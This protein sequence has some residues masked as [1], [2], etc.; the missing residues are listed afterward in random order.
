MTSSP[1]SSSTSSS[2][3]LCHLTAACDPVL[4]TSLPL[5]TTSGEEDTPPSRYVTQ[6]SYDDVISRGAG[7][8]R[9]EPVATSV[10]R[11]RVLRTDITR[12]QSAPVGFITCDTTCPLDT[13][14]LIVNGTPLLDDLYDHNV[15]SKSDDISTCQSCGRATPDD[16][17]CAHTGSNDSFN[18]ASEGA[19]S[20]T[21]IMLTTTLYTTPP[22]EHVTGNNLLR[23][24]LHSHD[25]LVVNS[26]SCNSLPS[27]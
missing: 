25:S 21:D 20:D 16:V 24:R 10:C 3:S 11:E 8:K 13:P 15:T 19:G 14:T 5:S 4:E 6:P 17:T 1:C 7:L 9:G 26:A 27:R 22:R 18:T 23:N 12:T 2:S